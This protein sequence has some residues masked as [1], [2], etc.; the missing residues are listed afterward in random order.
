MK[1]MGLGSEVEDGDLHR[2]RSDL[3]SLLHQVRH[4]FSPFLS[5]NSILSHLQNFILQS[6][7]IP[8]NQCNHS[9]FINLT[10]SFWERLIIK[11]HSLIIG[12]AD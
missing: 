8:E 6:V 2:L 11:I 3:S 5:F 1:K 4:T 10:P 7:R 12:F 9:L